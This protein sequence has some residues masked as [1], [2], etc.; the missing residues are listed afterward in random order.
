MVNIWLPTRDVEDFD[1]GFV[2]TEAFSVDDEF[3][4]ELFGGSRAATVPHNPNMSVFT[5][6]R[7]KVNEFY[8][9]R[10]TSLKHANGTIDNKKRGILHGAFRT[11]PKDGIL[12]HSLETRC[13]VFEQP[14]TDLY[15]IDKFHDDDKTLKTLFT[16]N[17]EHSLPKQKEQFEKLVAAGNVDMELKTKEAHEA[18]SETWVREKQNPLPE[19]LGTLAQNVR[20]LNVPEDRADLH[21]SSHAHTHASTFQSAFLKN[22]ETSESGRL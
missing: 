18:L 16:E 12:R 9:F 10:T 20:E 13:M 14:S 4:V 15:I 3:E 17:I 21:S 22:I 1:L 7:M 19:D 5:K 6:K 8:V 2:P 11:N